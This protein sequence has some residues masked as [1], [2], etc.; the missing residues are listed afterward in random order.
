MKTRLAAATAALLFSSAMVAPS[1]AATIDLS[2][3]GNFTGQPGYFEVNQTFVLPAN[4]INVALNIS[5]LS[6]DDRAVVQ[7]NGTDVDATGIFANQGSV[8][9]F[10]FGQN[11]PTVDYTYNAPFVRNITVTSGFNIGGSNLFALLLND[12]NNGIFGTVLP[13]TANGS[14]G[15][16]AN[17]TFGTGVPEP[18]TW[19]LMILGFGAIGGAMRRRPSVAAK[20]RFA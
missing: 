12:T 15:I 19:A 1:Q 6:V 4:A 10:N 18:A 14:Y 17:V 5:F 11:A 2:T 13:T 20:V 9:Q 8:G 3:N 7:L 16:A